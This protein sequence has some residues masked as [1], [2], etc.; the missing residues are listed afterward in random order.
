MQKRKQDIEACVEDYWNYP[1]SFGDY[2]L[3]A[4]VLLKDLKTV[5]GRSIS[6][7]SSFFKPQSYCFHL[8]AGERRRRA[9]SSPDANRRHADRD[10]PQGSGCTWLELFFQSITENIPALSNTVTVH[11]SYIM[12]VCTSDLDRLYPKP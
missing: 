9:L 3:C 1:L 5:T 4:L 12:P 2:A 8:R 11:S 10:G 7:W 6:R